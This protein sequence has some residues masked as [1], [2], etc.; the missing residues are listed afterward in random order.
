MVMKRYI[1]DTRTRKE[2]PIPVKITRS[3]GLQVHMGPLVR[4]IYNI[5]V[6]LSPS[7]Q[8][9]GCAA[10][11]FTEH[12]ALLP[13]SQES[14]TCRIQRQMNGPYH[15]NLSCHPVS[16]MQ[17]ALWSSGQSSWLQIQRSRFDSRRYKVYWDVVG[18]ERGS[19]Y[20]REY[21]WGATWKKK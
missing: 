4:P 15:P 2:R 5:F 17:L 8:S 20:P 21:N 19:T 14:S 13:F 10:Q 9:A 12:T 18:V 1:G 7:W 11:H 16:G 3:V 6:E